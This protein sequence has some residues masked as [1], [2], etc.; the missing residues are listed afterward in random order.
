MKKFEIVVSIEMTPEQVREY[1]GVH[2]HGNVS[3]V[4]SDLADWIGEAIEVS[5]LGTSDLVS[6]TSIR[7]AAG[8]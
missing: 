4:G 3:G 7:E 5:E 1:A 2:T 8:K 6:I